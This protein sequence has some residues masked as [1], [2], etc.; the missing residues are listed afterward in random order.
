M[1]HV[2]R[3][4]KVIENKTVSQL[5]KYDLILLLQFRRKVYGCTEK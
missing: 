3:A 1:F 2:H 4:R 5:N